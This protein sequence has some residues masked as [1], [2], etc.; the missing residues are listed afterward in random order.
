MNLF[1]N[2]ICALMS[3]WHHGDAGAI[4][5]RSR[6]MGLTQLENSHTR[7]QPGAIAGIAAA[8]DRTANYR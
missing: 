5:A 7:W 3:N 6:T 1:D 2:F 4:N 8:A